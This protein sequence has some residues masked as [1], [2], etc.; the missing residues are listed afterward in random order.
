MLFSTASVLG[1]LYD[2]SYWAPLQISSAQSLTG[3]N[4]LRIV[5]GGTDE[6]EESASQRM[7]H[8]QQ[9]HEQWIFRIG[10]S[11]GTY[12]MQFESNRTARLVDLLQTDEST[13][14]EGQHSL[15]RA[16]QSFY[17]KLDP[18]PDRKIWQIMQKNRLHEKD[19]HRRVFHARKG[20]KVSYWP[21][22]L[23]TDELGCWYLSDETLD[24]ILPQWRSLLEPDRR[25]ISRNRMVWW[26]LSKEWSDWLLSEQ[27]KLKSLNK[28]WPVPWID[29][30]ED[31]G[32][33]TERS[34]I[35]KR[36][37][38]GPVNQLRIIDSEGSPSH[39]MTTRSASI[40]S[41]ASNSPS[42]SNHTR[43]AMDVSD[44]EHLESEND[45]SQPGSSRSAGSGDALHETSD[46]LEAQDLT[47]KSNQTN[48]TKET[49]II[50]ICHV[51]QAISNQLQ[52]V[53]V[54]MK[55]LQ[56]QQAKLE[57]NMEEW[58]V[59]GQDAATSDASEGA[60]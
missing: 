52:G 21:I 2:I 36:R 60:F 48:Q 26:N 5:G 41:I 57:T 12:L 50:K 14:L 27:G 56:S 55:A 8:V 19:Q 35:A 11:S 32:K 10:Q 25:V 46:I 22:A 45:S 58:L 24:C 16:K 4:F 33:I 31:M 29:H 1:R 15:S 43:E 9:A 49:D 23:A 13:L 3:I 38:R 47:S 28:P 51:I 42:L 30:G 7:Q 20:V 34:K 40:A 17:P 18:L 54:G 39:S 59:A 53:E 37:R 6:N 44:D